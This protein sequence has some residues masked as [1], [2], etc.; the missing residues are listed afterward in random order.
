VVRWGASF[1]LA[2][3]LVATA[4]S[5]VRSQRIIGEADV[6]VLVRDWLL[7]HVSPGSRV[8]IHDEM[9]AYLP[10]DPVQLRDCAERVT[11]AAAYEEKWRTEGV[12][13]S[14]ADTRSID[15]MVLNDEHFSAFWCRRE[16][17]AASAL[18]FH[19]V[20]Y[21]EEPRFEAVLEH[22]AMNDFRARSRQATGGIDVLVM[23]RPVDVGVAPVQVFRT[24]RGQRVIYMR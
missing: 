9:N 13:T 18:H 14:L 11:T 16:L 12:K 22:D 4:T 19:V 15:S 3:A 10:R 5:V 7:A 8:A 20:T 23:N 6:D 24:A 17:G 21:H 2:A 1:V